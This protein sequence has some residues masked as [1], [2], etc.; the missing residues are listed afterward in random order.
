MVPLNSEI[1]C[2]SESTEV[3]NETSEKFSSQLIA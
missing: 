2:L 3:I 1:I